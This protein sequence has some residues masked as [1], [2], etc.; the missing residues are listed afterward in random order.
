MT[1][2]Q[3]TPLVSIGLAVYNGERYLRQTM[4]SLLAQDH[5]H[6]EIIV[7]DNA[8]TDSTAAIAR[9]YAARDG[10]VRYHCNPRNLGGVG[11]FKQVRRLAAGRYF[12]WASCHDLWAPDFL[13]RCVAVMEADPSVVLCYPFAAIIDAADK[14]ISHLSDRLDTR[15]L[16]QARRYLRVI[17]RHTSYII[18]GLHRTD[19]IRQVPFRMSLGPD[20]LTLAEMSLRGAFAC[21]PQELFSMRRLGDFGDWHSYFRKLNLALTPARGPVLVGRF[22]RHHLHILRRLVAGRR[23]RVLLGALTVVLLPLRCWLV[24]AAIVCEGA[25]PRFTAWLRRRPA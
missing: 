20:N 17:W 12:M 10:R 14:P 22:I 1:D 6:L 23:Q 21:V 18:Y 25:L 15:G 2:P 4:D 24:F 8:S 5:H 3:T 16:G 19:A 7:S 13:S 9:E 11:N